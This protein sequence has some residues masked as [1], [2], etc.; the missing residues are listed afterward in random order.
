[1][2]FPDPKDYE[3]FEDFEKAWHHAYQQ[4]N[5]SWR[6]QEMYLNGQFDELPFIEWEKAGGVFH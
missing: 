3:S 4:H 2:P 5:P 1:M 6:T